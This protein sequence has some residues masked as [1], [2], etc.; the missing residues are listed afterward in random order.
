MKEK[1]EKAEED[2]VPADSKKKRKKKQFESYQKQQGQSHV[3]LWSPW[4]PGLNRTSLLSGHV[5]LCVCVCVCV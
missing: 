2:N 1:E 3:P 4:K 5:T